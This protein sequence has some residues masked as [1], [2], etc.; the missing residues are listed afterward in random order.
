LAA[1]FSLRRSL[2]VFCGFF[3]C[4]F[5]GLSELLLMTT[6]AGALRSQPYPALGGPAVCPLGSPGR[7]CQ[8][9][10]AAQLVGGV[11]LLLNHLDVPSGQDLV[12]LEAFTNTGQRLI[13]FRAIGSDQGHGEEE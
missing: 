7:E 3:F 12:A 11:R 1:R 4:C 5:F 2:S 9:S 13:Q 6:S 8:K 10:H